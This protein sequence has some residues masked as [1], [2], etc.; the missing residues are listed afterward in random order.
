M[1]HILFLFTLVLIN[2]ISF[3]QNTCNCSIT[4][5][6]QTWMT[7][8]LTAVTYRNGDTI[9]QIKDPNVWATLTTGAWC[10]YA[11][12]STNE[13]VYGNLY[14]WYAV[15]DPR[16]LA[17]WCWRIPTL[18]EWLE[19]TTVC[20]SPD[21]GTKM[22]T[23]GNSLWFGHQ[24]LGATNSSGFSAVPGGCRNDVGSFFG[25]NY[26]AYFWTSTADVN[27]SWVASYFAIAGI[28]GNS[29]GTD[30][31]SALSVRCIKVCN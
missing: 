25:K 8:N 26:A 22:R 18:S 17:P 30:K 7:H 29:G 5:C 19:L 16:G 23:T 24:N 28:G 20:L 3:S 1:K 4:P 31:K 9:P 14:N 2:T 15:T 10:Y 27:L 6:T 11:N 13:G 21:F 12:D